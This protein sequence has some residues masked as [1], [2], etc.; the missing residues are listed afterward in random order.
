MIQHND[1]EIQEIVRLVVER[2]SETHRSPG[3]SAGQPPLNAL[4][5]IR[6]GVEPHAEKARVI[7][8]KVIALRDIEEQLDDISA[9]RVAPTAL[10]TPAVKDELRRRGIAVRRDCGAGSVKPLT[11]ATE[12]SVAVRPMRL[13]LPASKRT[14]CESSQQTLQ[15]VVVDEH[16][17]AAEIARWLSGDWEKGDRAIWCSP[18]PFAAL[19]AISALSRND[20]MR[21]VGLFEPADLIQA[22][23]EAQ[24]HVLIVDDRKWL[25][26]QVLKLARNWLLIL[27][28]G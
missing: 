2:L 26:H 17:S 6:K 21:A 8:G 1:R 18:E 9:I 28:V 23:R 19:V 14:I 25:A 7:S 10:L 15:P 27:E 13:L 11:N 16:R 5:N 12:D 20:E 22:V 24:P 4:Q 3:L